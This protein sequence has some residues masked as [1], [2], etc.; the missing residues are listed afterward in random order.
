MHIN[1]KIFIRYIDRHLFSGQSL[2]MPERWLTLNGFF[3]D[4][5]LSSEL[6]CLGYNVFLSDLLCWFWSIYLLSL[7]CSPYFSSLIFSTYLFSLFALVIFLV[8][9]TLP[10]MYWYFSFL[11]SFVCFFIRKYFS[12]RRWSQTSRRRRRKHLQS[13]MRN[14][15]RKTGNK[16]YSRQ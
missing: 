10:D 15:W 16:K 9:F 3:P 12:F 4:V 2:R 11:I 13:L 1:I 6:N 7:F 8:S 14:P 5:L